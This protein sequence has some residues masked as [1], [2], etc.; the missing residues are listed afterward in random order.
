[1]KDIGNTKELTEFV[2]NNQRQRLGMGNASL[3]L[4]ANI[5]REQI[6]ELGSVLAYDDT[7]AAL[8][9][10]SKQIVWHVAMPKSGSTWVSL[11][12][13]KGL[14][15]KGW[16]T[17]NLVPAHGRRE[18]QIVPVEL[19]RQKSL[20]TNVFAPHQHC[21]HSEYAF[22]FIKKFK[23]KLMLQV[24]SIPDCIVSLVDHFD[25]SVGEGPFAYLNNT[26]WNSYD[27]E[28]KLRFVIDL[29]LPWYINF[30]VGWSQGLKAHEIDH[31]LVRYEDMLDNTQTK[32]SQLA[33]FCDPEVSDA[34][35]S[36]WLANTQKRDTRK[37]KAVSGRGT[38]L[39]QWVHT[40]LKRLISYYPSVDFSDVGI[41][42]D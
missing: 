16:R 34:D 3:D 8:Q 31:R 41:P 12:L 22:N 23:V 11:V 7:L 21:M 5:T 13:K 2:E 36:A 17:T 15:K 35:V 38:Q 24:R 26:L 28:Q 20:D 30:W 25:K 19:L 1:M 39:P 6:L 10:S 27:S 9:N 29:V 37:N 14:A 42:R 33:S 32:F 40:H 18:Q 4:P